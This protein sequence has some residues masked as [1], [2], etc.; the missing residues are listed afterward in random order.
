MAKT[1]DLKR[2]WEPSQAAFQRLLTWLDEGS[3]SDGERYLDIRDRLVRYFAR[4]KCAGPDDLAD[5][6]LN[7]VARRLEETGSIDDVTPARYCY[8]VAKFLLLESLRQHARRPG[9][10][11]RD[12]RDIETI[13]TDDTAA[14]RERTLAC[15]ERCLDASPP[16][17]RAL[18]LDYY[19]TEPG[20]SSARRRQLAEQ[21]GLTANALAIRACRI[22]SR[23]ERC[24]RTCL[25]R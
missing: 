2:H 6:T 4:R 23:L 15:L 24:V 19:R 13:S 25:E 17:E 12:D 7:R 9:T 22:R 11:W 18:I 3:D 16:S 21:L 8:I 20:P 1:T 10:A 14:D 5:E